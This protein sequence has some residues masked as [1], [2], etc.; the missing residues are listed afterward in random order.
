MPAPLIKH[1]AEQTTP[2][3][4]RVL[5]DE[6]GGVAHL[7]AHEQSLQH[8]EDQKQDRRGRERVCAGNQTDGRC[9]DAHADDCDHQGCLAAHTVPHVAPDQAADGA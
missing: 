1:R 4:R 2:T 8:P 9:R 3:G 6:R 5:D 7:A